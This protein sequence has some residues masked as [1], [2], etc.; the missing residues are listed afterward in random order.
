MQMQQQQQQQQQMQGMMMPMMPM[1]MP[2]QAQMMQMQMMQRQMGMGGC[3][4]GMGGCGMGGC[5]GM[6]MMGGGGCGCGMGM[7]G[8]GMG[9]CGMGMG[10]F[11]QQG[12]LEGVV[13]EWSDRGFGFITFADGRRAYVHHSSLRNASADQERRAT[14]LTVGETVEAQVV[15]DKEK[16]GKWAAVNVFRKAEA[17]MA[18]AKGTFTGGQAMPGQGGAGM[19]SSMGS[20]MGAPGMGMGMGMPGMSEG[21]WGGDGGDRKQGV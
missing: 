21:S 15:E 20:G 9:G 12:H 6:G 18:K 8:C 7:G 2:M 14:E 17:I 16:P 4:M 3:G 5:G 19:G 13:V 10:G 1:M 11:D